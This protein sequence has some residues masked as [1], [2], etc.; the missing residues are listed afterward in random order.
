MRTPSSGTQTRVVALSTA[1]VLVACS[2]QPPPELACEMREHAIFDRAAE[3]RGAVT[4]EAA[5][6]TVAG[7]QE[8][9][10]RW[11]DSWTGD[12]VAYWAIIGPDGAVTSIVTTEQTDTGWFAMSREDCFEE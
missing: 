1:M 2:W 8:T 5:L 4:S 11:P 6:A 9:W 7:G 3:A 10:Q 12:R